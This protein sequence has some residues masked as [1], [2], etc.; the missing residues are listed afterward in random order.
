MDPHVITLKSKLYV[1]DYG[2]GVAGDTGGL[3]KGMHIDLGYDEDNLKLWYKWVD[4]YLLAPPPSRDQIRWVLP[5][6][7]RERR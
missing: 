6:Y 5:S 2:V 3:I 1:P 7:P 4:V